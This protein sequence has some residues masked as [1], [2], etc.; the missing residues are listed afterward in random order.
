MKDEIKYLHAKKQHL[1][2]EIY[3]LH[4]TLANTWNNTWLYMLDT[5]LAKLQKEIQKRY[6]NLDTK[7][8]KLAKGQTTIQQ[9]NQSFYPRVINDT[10]IT[11]SKQEMAMLQK[12]LKY[13]L[14]SKPKN[15]LQNL[16][17]EAETAIQNRENKHTTKKQ[18]HQI[19]SKDNAARGKNNQ[20]HKVQNQH[21]QRHSHTCR[22]REFHCHLTNGSI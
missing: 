21:P 3:K 14:H 17:L 19:K 20:K 5:I 1:N 12:G 13:N 7:L 16:A 22:Q 2:Y 4:L 18:Q 9:H 6:Q 8:K 10:D 15:W 11:F